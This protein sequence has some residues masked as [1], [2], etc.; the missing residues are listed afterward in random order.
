MNLKDF[1]RPTIGKI[2]IFVVL[3]LVISKIW[4]DYK[5]LLPDAIPEFGAPLGFYSKATY[6]FGIKLE[7]PIIYFNYLNLI[8]DLIIWYFFSCLI[9]FI[10]IG[11]IQKKKK[12][13]WREFFKFTLLKFIIF[14]IIL[15]IN[16]YAAFVNLFNKCGGPFCVG[17]INSILF[18]LFSTPLILSVIYYTFYA[19]ESFLVIL[20]ILSMIY[21]YFLA[22]LTV[23]FIKRNPTTKLEKIVKKE[24]NGIKY[25]LKPSKWK[26]LILIPLVILSI[27]VGFF[28]TS[29]CFVNEEGVSVCRKCGVEGIFNPVLRP[30]SFLIGNVYKGLI[31]SG[32]IAICGGPALY[33]PIFIL[34]VSYLYII[35]CFLHLIISKSK[36]K[37][38]K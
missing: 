17:I 9:T 31:E 12:I 27:F 3:S 10:M 25:F 11:L 5:P 37:N 21:N 7:K 13:N 23:Y 38:K 6:S 26:I 24:K 1:F 22:C 19:G 34:D 35:S 15:L 29:N 36:S 4:M 20:F 2:I 33:W 32:Y 28:K 30:F 14:V 8:I 18:T 16:L